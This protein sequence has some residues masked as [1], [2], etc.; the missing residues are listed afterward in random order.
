MPLEYTNVKA[1]CTKPCKQYTKNNLLWY[2]MMTVYIQI[3]AAI[4]TLYSTV[5]V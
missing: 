4:L 2:V 3:D 1:V 5:P